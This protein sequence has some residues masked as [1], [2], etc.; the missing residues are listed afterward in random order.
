LIILM[1][2]PATNMGPRS[3]LAA[4]PR[5]HEALISLTAL[6]YIEEHELLARDKLSDAK[7][8]LQALFLRASGE[9]T[10]LRRLIDELKTTRN[11]H[12]AFG[13]IAGT[14]GAV[15]K[16][17]ASVDERVASLRKYTEQT[18][19]SPSA[20]T[21]FVGPFLSFSHAFVQKITA[22]ADSLEEYL[23]AREQEARAKAIF[24]VA[25]Q[26]R[27]R[28]R[29]RLA[30]K[31]AQTEGEVENRIKNE[32]NTS[33]NYGEA[34][35]NMLQAE[36]KSRAVEKEVQTH[37]KEMRAM[38]QAA[39]NPSMRDRLVLVKP[40]DDIFKRFSEAV[41]RHPE[42][43]RIKDRLRELFK[44]YHHAHGM[45]QLDYDMLRQGLQALAQNT[46]AYFHAKEE[47]QDLATKR[48]K[49][50]KIEGLIPFLENG[51][52]LATA[53]ESAAY[54][55]FSRELSNSISKTDVPWTHIAE[56]LLRAKVQAE[57]ELNTRL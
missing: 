45:F 47:D 1:S 2:R 36:T 9:E 8:S 6:H 38:C 35:A 40:E 34:E 50:R 11:I 24:Q 44:L 48:D 22:F 10:L 33:V 29:Q 3:N 27:E 19:P 30:G 13:S 56:S 37:L 42:I 17:V 4:P 41:A 43:D 18:P 16:S 32:L 23:S 54:P 49:L 25:S 55:I 53:K 52:K 46:E 31:L 28:L 5:E 51:A 26:V 12:H 20:A 39:M 57:A 15:R 7:K 14:I 21:D